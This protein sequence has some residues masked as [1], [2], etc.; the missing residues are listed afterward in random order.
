MK[1]ISTLLFLVNEIETDL[2]NLQVFGTW[3]A[4]KE[5]SLRD[6]SYE[7]APPEGLIHSLLCYASAMEV[8]ETESIG[9]TE[10]ILN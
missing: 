4:K 3:G 6:V 7:N 10:W 5:A 1:N 2:K 9:R 8:T